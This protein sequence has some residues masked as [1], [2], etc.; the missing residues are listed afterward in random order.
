MD[1]RAQH[2]LPVGPE[3]S[4]SSPDVGVVQPIKKMTTKKNTELMSLEH[5]SAD[6]FLQHYRMS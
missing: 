2:L 6:E 1:V 4:C 5:G 3:N